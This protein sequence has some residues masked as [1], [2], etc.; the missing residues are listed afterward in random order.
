M[1]KLEVGLGF[2]GKIAAPAKQILTKVP[3][4][5]TLMAHHL[6]KGKTLTKKVKWLVVLAG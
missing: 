1:A 3:I 5:E 6:I 4:I 2:R